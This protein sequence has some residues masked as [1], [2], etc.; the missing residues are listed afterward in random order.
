MYNSDRVRCR[1]NL[2]A[3]EESVGM[4]TK[5]KAFR[6]QSSPEKAKKTARMMSDRGGAMADPLLKQAIDPN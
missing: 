3:E 1:L 2:K 5:G 6:A 4:R